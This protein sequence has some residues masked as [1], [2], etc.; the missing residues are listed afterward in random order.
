[1]SPKHMKSLIVLVVGLLA[2][3][4]GGS[5]EKAAPKS[6]AK[7]D[8]TPKAKVKAAP[9]VEAKK[10]ESP[11]VAPS[12][13]I[14]NPIVEKEIRISLDKPKGELTEADLVKVTVRGLNFIRT[15]AKSC[16]ASLM[17]LLEKSATGILGFK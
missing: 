13:F 7:V 6:Q 10:T 3:G 4:C 12:K 17:F 8:A 16:N 14:T 15:D 11:T 5:K 1:M 9:K 2:V